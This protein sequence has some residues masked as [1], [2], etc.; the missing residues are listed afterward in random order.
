[1]AAVCGP[2]EAPRL[3]GRDNFDYSW[4]KDWA[5]ADPGH[6]SAK[7]FDLV[8]PPEAVRAIRFEGGRPPAYRGDGEEAEPDPQTFRGVR[9]LSWQT[10]VAFD[11]LLA[12]HERSR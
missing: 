6:S 10:A 1:V 4:A 7:Y 2:E 8:V 5:V 9:A 11:R 3:T 12:E